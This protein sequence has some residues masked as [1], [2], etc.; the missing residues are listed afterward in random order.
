MHLNQF[1]KPSKYTKSLS[2]PLASILLYASNQ[3]NVHLPD[4]CS[5]FIDKN[6]GGLSLKTP[7]IRRSVW[8]TCPPSGST[9]Q[10]HTA[11]LSGVAQAKSE[12]RR[13]RI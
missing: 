1:V 5:S 10:P 11:S 6:G 8:W 7:F 2:K 13:R 3:I 9:A 12:P 4:Y